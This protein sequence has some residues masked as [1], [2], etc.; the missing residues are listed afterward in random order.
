MINSAINSADKFK[1]PKEILNTSGDTIFP[2]FLLSIFQYCTEKGKES[3]RFLGNIFFFTHHIFSSF[4]I[5]ILL[6]EMMK[7][8]LPQ[9][10]VPCEPA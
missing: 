8:C 1:D 9:A 2:L 5:Y 6:V 3:F 7:L 10:L 4:N